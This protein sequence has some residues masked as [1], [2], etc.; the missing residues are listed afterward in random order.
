MND[1]ERLEKGQ[2]HF[3]AIIE[4]AGRPKE[5]VEETIRNNVEKIKKQEDMDVMKEDFAEIKKQ[6][7]Q[8]DQGELWSTFVELELWIKDLPSLFDFC[9]DYMPSSVDV[10]EPK[11][12]HLK[13]REVSGLLNDLQANLHKM[14]ILVK[15][16]TNENLFLKKNAN[17]LLQN[18]IF[19]LTLKQGKTVEQ[20]SKVT[21]FEP[22]NLKN[23]LERL[24]KKEKL[25]KEGDEYL[26]KK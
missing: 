3:R 13:E 15:N 5:H 7:D 18:I 26:L 9:F 17:N 2:V 16:I 21:G 1:S 14:N 23:F 25:V 19:V 24:V 20:L 22:D 10:I 12:L 6:E 8:K 11:E 4:V